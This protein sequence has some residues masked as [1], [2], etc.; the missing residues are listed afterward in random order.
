M[1]NFMALIEDI[2]RSNGLKDAT[3]HLQRKA[4][5]LPGFFRTTKLWDLIIMDDSNL[6]AG[7]EFKSQVGPSFGNNCNNRAEEAIGTAHDFWR[8]YREQA[9]GDIP[10]PFL[11]WLVLVEDVIEPRSPVKENSPHFAVFPEFKNASYLD[12]Y[13]LLCRK[14]VLE[15]LYTAATVLATPRTAIRDGSFT[16]NK[17]MTNLDNFVS[18]FAGHIAVAATRNKE[19]AKRRK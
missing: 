8:A 19:S 5:T 10:R 16:Q 6:I 18:T 11:G 4:L 2:T 9:F 12:R 14:L 15:Q 3:V 7:L 1:D 17:D 13:H